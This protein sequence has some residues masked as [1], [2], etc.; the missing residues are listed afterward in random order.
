VLNGDRPASDE[1]G[2]SE[3]ESTR[4]LRLQVEAVLDRLRPGLLFDGGNVELV[5]V[6]EGGAVSLLF[7]GA[8]AQCPAQLA[9]LRLV[10]EPTLRSEVP[11]V[12]HVVPVAPTPG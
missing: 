6:N 7:Q 9:T 1:V 2:M 4:R 5:G 10:I 12:T 3:V 11:A 8:C